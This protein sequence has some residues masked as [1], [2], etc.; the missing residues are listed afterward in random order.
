MTRGKSQVHLILVLLALVSSMALAGGCHQMVPLAPD[1][2]DYAPTLAPPLAQRLPGVGTSV[3]CLAPDFKLVNLN[4]REVSLSDYR[5]KPV[6]LNFWTYCS[7]CKEELPYIQSA[8]DARG[9]LA[10]GLVVLAVNVTQLPDQVEQ[11][12]SYYG[13]TFEIILDTWGTAASDYSIHQIP[14]TFFIDR[15]GIILDIQVG[16]FSGPAVIGPKLTELANR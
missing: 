9:S 11:F 16:A 5:G 1:Y 7:A 13:Y 3:G 10:P 6:M 12:V 2:S 8:Y 14:T 15:N 4:G